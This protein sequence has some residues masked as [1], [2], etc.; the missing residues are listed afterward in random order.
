MKVDLRTFLIIGL[1]AMVLPL[2][3]E[4]LADVDDGDGEGSTIPA[5]LPDCD[6]GKVAGH[7]VTCPTDTTKE[8]IVQVYKPKVPGGLN[9]NSACV[10][11]GTF[12]R[13]NP[14]LKK[15]TV[16]PDGALPACNPGEVSTVADEASFTGNGTY[17]ETNG[18]KKVC[19]H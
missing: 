3:G 1:L 9:F 11:H 14:G 10:C 2:A 15:G 19:Y 12:N 6:S 7:T 18:G 8:S 17:C 4:A 5:T 16:V 13:C